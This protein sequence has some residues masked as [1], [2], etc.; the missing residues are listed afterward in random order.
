MK[1]HRLSHWR[2]LP[3]GTSLYT[4]AKLSLMRRVS[5]LAKGR[6]S[7][8]SFWLK[9]GALHIETP[10]ACLFV[11][12]GFG[13]WIPAG[14]QHCLTLPEPMSVLHVAMDELVW[15]ECGDLSLSVVLLDGSLPVL[16]LNKFARTSL[17]S[18]NQIRA[19]AAS[20]QY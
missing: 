20:L 5:L 18:L 19:G 10:D 9:K 3:H 2:Y 16:S 7:A 1:Q 17:Q 11:P 4:L 6:I 13:V 12:A 14:V 8:V 15:G